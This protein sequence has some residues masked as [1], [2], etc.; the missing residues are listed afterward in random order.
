MQVVLPQTPGVPPPPQL[1]GA[2]HE[3]QLRTPPQPSAHEPQFFPSAAQVVGV[4]E[5]PAHLPPVPQVCPAGHVPQ[6]A[7]VPPQPSGAGPHWML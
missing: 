3:P 5:E 6:L 1:S 2:L 4:Q 7:M